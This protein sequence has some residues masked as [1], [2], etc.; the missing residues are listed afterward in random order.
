MIK[1][2]IE[3][4]RNPVD[5]SYL[6]RMEAIEWLEQHQQRIDPY[7]FSPDKLPEAK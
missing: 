3:I 7:L 4:L 2:I 6:E 1:K 5:Y